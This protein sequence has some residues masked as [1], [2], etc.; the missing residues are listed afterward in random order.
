MKYRKWDAKTKASIILEQNG[1]SGTYSGTHAVTLSLGRA[2]LL[3]LQDSSQMHFE[4]PD[5]SNFPQRSAR[6]PVTGS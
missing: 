2:G 6:S 4:F 1:Y 5:K 3:L